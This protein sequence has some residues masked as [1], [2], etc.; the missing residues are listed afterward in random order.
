MEFIP[1]DQ[2]INEL[3]DSFQPLMEKY[4]IDN[5]GVFEEEGQDNTYYVG[6][7]VRKDGKVY[8]V[9]LPYT[10]NVDGHLARAP[11]GWMVETDE[12][13]NLDVAGYDD[14]DEVFQRFLM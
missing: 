5:I 3:Q 14:L 8:M 10:K 6:Y 9:H 7:T 11:G 2:L 4:N 12:P 13:S 1:R